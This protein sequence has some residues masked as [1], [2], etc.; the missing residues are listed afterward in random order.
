[1]PS[2]C[3]RIPTS[4]RCIT[5][6]KL[7]GS[8]VQVNVSRGGLPKL[9]VSE[10]FLTPLG[11]E[12]DAC[13]HPAIHG[14]P[15]KAVLLLDAE[16]VD[17]LREKGYPVFY[18]ALGENLTTRGLDRRQFRAGQQYRAGDALIELTTLRKPCGSLDVYGPSIK[19]EIFDAQV[20]AGDTSSPLWGMS[21]FYARVLRPGLVRANDIIVLVA[22]LA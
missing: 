11:F 4:S 3:G 15:E 21:G 20:K 10:G 8:I 16:T 5:T 6:F 7:T 12:G 13:V 22:V 18:G 1:M 17:E 2:A 19:Q 9:A 14:G